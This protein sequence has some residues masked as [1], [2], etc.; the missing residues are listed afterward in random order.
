MLTWIGGDITKMGEKI[1]LTDIPNREIRAY[2]R[3]L[4][5]GM[6]ADGLVRRVGDDVYEYTEKGIEYAEGWSKV[7][8]NEKIAEAVEEMRELGILNVP[9]GPIDPWD[10][11]IRWIATELYKRRNDRSGDLITDI[12]AIYTYSDR[13]DRTEKSPS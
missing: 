9:T 2:L 7:P 5:D 6:V 10:A 12:I 3:Q 13:L 11:N 1:D 8:E 4:H